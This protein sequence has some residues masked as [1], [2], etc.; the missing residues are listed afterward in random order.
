[1]GILLEKFMWEF[2]WGNFSG[3]GGNLWTLTPPST[4]IF[5]KRLKKKSKKVWYVKGKYKIRNMHYIKEFLFHLW[6]LFL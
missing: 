4:W 6:V 3:G 5:E 1:M 2:Q